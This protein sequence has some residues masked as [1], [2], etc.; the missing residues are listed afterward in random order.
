M[1]A[2]PL[3]QRYAEVRR[4][5]LARIDGLSAE[6]LC[7]Q[8]MPDASPAKWH[9]AHTTWFFETLV[10]LP[11]AEPASTGLARGCTAHDPVFQLLFNSY[12]EA[13]GP[14]HPRPQRGLLTRPTLAEVLAYRRAVD[15]AMADLIGAAEARA[16]EPEVA[17]VLALIELG[18]HHEQQHQELLLTDLLHLFSLNPLR[19]ALRAGPLPLD[20]CAAAGWIERPGGIARIG[21]DPAR[22]GRFL[23]DNEGPA[24]EALLQPHA[25]ATRLVTQG[26]YQAFIDDGGYRRAALW[27]SDGWATVQAQGWTAPLHWLDDGQQFTLHGVQ[28][29]QADQPVRHLSLYEA[30]AYAEW[31]GA[32]LPT[33][34]EWEAAA[35]AEPALAQSH[36]VAWQ[37]TR[38]SYDPYPRYH[39]AAGAVGEYNGK[40][41]VGQLVLRGSSLATPDGHARDS[42]R[43]FFPPAAR[44]QFTGLRLAKDL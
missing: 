19:P 21:H 1:V 13:L 12:Y 15:A 4:Q 28:S 36:G 30:A 5:T 18:L 42:Y 25:L 23:F 31:A 39:P 3:A 27:L 20:A 22:D 41:M 11:Q 44:W 17:A 7:V 24:H 37:W 33:E 38:S 43:N 32:R 9:L 40:F 14:R 29:R 26:E 8:S 10:L 2:T 6:D 34:F 35:R 16:D